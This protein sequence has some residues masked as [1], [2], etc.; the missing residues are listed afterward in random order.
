MIR[1]LDFHSVHTSLDE[2]LKQY[3]SHKLEGLDKYV[4]PAARRSLRIEIF[5]KENKT[6][7]AKRY[8]FEVIAHLPKEK[9]RISEE[10]INMHA[11]VDIVE[12]KLKQAL[13]K[14]K[15]IHGNPK[16]WSHLLKR[17]LRKTRK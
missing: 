9:I 10:T 5:A 3:I 15:N 17:S 1:N 7:G 4:S 2:E 8:E 12:E 11:A 6:H 13:I 14:Y 16:R